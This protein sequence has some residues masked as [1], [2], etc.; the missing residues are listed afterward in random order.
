MDD[1]VQHQIKIEHDKIE[2]YDP[3]LIVKEGWMDKQ[4]RFLGSWRKRWTILYKNKQ[5]MVTLCTFKKKKIYRNPTEI[6]NINEYIKISKLP[7]K[8][9]EFKLYSRSLQTTFMFRTNSKNDLTEWI[10]N[11]NNFVHSKFEKQ[12]D[13]E[14]TDTIT[15][16]KLNINA[17]DTSNIDN[18]ILI[19]YQQLISMGFDD[20][21]SWNAVK[22]YYG[23]F[24][25]S[26]NFLLQFT[27]DKEEKKTASIPIQEQST[28]YSSNNI[29]DRIIENMKIAHIRKSKD[30]QIAIVV[31]NLF[32]IYQKLLFQA[33]KKED[34]IEL[35]DSFCNIKESLHDQ[36]L[37]YAYKYILNYVQQQ[38]CNAKECE[39]INYRYRNR[40]N[41]NDIIH[42]AFNLKR[43]LIS[44][45]HC[46]ML[47]Q[48]DLYKLKPNEIQEIQQMNNNI[49]NDRVQLLISK[50]LTE[51]RSNIDAVKS[52]IKQTQ[53][54]Y[55]TNWCHMNQ[56]KS[57]Q[58]DTFNMLESY[59]NDN[60][61]LKQYKDKIMLYCKMKG[62]E[63]NVI[64]IK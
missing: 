53:N 2:A 57:K 4:S 7:Q 1:L 55:Q 10:K 44:E 36:T 52:H 23:D 19:S 43:E 33:N 17:K 56:N 13:K 54:K 8:E 32:N 27:N 21:M 60:D 38:Q 18:K 59:L 37:Y 5:N 46:F 47:H 25:Q 20:K 24:N 49:N 28:T 61:Q 40:S 34:F 29:F 22:K 64:D 63:F 58:N 35:Y 26:L 16:N 9:Q 42:S 11:I 48:Y 50:R 14:S 41:G 51:K 12:N 6:I 39:Y 3:N 15:R 45:I 30:D 31:M 62:I